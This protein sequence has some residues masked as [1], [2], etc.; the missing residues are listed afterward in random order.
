MER[1]LNIDIFRLFLSL[2]IIT[3][4]IQ[5]LFEEDSLMGWLISNGIARIA[6]PCFFLIS[7]YFMHQKFSDKVLLRKYLLHLLI[8]YIVWSL[9][10]LPT[11]YNTVEPRSLITFT[12]MGYYHL[13]FLPALIVGVILLY[14]SQRVIQKDNFILVIA[15]ILY[16]SGFL[17]ESLNFPYRIFYNGIF[18]GF[19]FIVFGYYL[20]KNEKS[21]KQDYIYILLMISLLFLFVESYLGYRSDFYRNIFLSLSILCPVLF[22]LILR[23]K[24]R[25]YNNNY[26]GAIASG[27]YLVHILVITQIFPLAET[28]N[29]YKLPLIILVSMILS[30]F[31]TLINKRLNIFL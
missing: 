8:I 21:I 20:K 26:I 17:I 12:L 3:P 30:I 6:V 7:G 10:Y 29:I 19:P 14:A 25:R 23:L 16:L 2:L 11:Y 13:W 31:T 24:P 1:N 9:I 5:P 18:F 22:L 28:Y 4:H 15:I 27:I